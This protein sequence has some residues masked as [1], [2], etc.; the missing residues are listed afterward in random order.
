[1][2]YKLNG[3]RTKYLLKK[4]AEGL[5]PDAIINRRK[6]GFGVP[7]SEWLSS[8]LKDFMLRYLSEENI[9]RQGFF[10][11]AYINDLI[12]D[13][14]KKKKD[15]RKLLWTLLIFQIWHEKYEADF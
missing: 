4:A 12:N 10:N 5:L 2:R 13:H 7:I 8:N 1:M 6:K 11:Y 3:L 9:K 14:L 15:N